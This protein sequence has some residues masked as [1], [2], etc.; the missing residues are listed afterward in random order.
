MNAPTSPW[1]APLPAL[2]F[3]SG[4]S[5][6]IG[7]EYLS[8]GGATL[9]VEDPG[10]GQ[11]IG[12]V[13]EAATAD[14][15]RAVE[16]AAVA[17]TAWWALGGLE[18]GRILAAIGA[19]FFRDRELFARV[20]S[21]DTGK[22]LSQA[23]RDVENTARYFEYFASLADKVSG[24]TIP[25]A[26]DSL[27]YTI[28]E[29][30]GVVAHITPWNAPLSQMARG[31]APSLAVGNAVV[32]KPSELTPLTTLLAGR[33]MADAGLPDDLYQVVVGRGQ[34][35]GT[36]LAEHEGVGHITFTGSVATGRNVG[37]IAAERI[38]GCS[39]ELGGKSP[40][41]VAAD[42]DL[43]AAA[44]VAAAAIAQNAGQTCFA[45]TRQLVHRSV[46]DA[47]LEFLVGQ[48]SQLT[49]GYGLDDADLGPMVTGAHLDR[50]ARFVESG[51]ADGCSILVG[52]DRT[53][54][55][56]HFFDPTVVLGT[57]NAVEIAREEVF[58]PVQYVMAFDDL[59]EAIA[60]ANDTPY[61]LGAGIFTR[62]VGVAH[63]VASRLRAGQVQVNRYG[64][65]GPDV[66]FGGYGRSGVGREKGLEALWHYTQL[67]TVLVAL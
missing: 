23:R 63:R 38:V 44:G 42:A 7:G 12:T 56:G 26:F 19:G 1:P 22:P 48:V 37:R 61:G 53:E 16:R 9:L 39:L 58:G 8:S 47:Y 6:F 18:R 5:A 64:G 13:G 14:I 15:D 52:G 51:R 66:P 65:S 55:D 43:R 46:L 62:D 57:S 30:Y 17:Q 32:V 11:S 60:L 31:V 10:T 24:M 40:T 45:T 25:G 59:E 54:R 41:I 50:V 35:V 3:P 49:P 29:P 4:T 34:E 67:K 27:T 28:R 33:L 20:E 21:I 2:P 36:P